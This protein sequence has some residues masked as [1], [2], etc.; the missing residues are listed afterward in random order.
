MHID[1][2]KTKLYTRRFNG[3]PQAK[4]LCCYCFLNECLE[5]GCCLS[6]CECNQEH[7]RS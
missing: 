4:Q 6:G 3:D 5:Q 1:I 2:D 7:G